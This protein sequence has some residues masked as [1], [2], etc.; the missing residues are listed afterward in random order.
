MP[1]D[2]RREKVGGVREEGKKHRHG[3]KKGETENDSG[4]KKKNKRD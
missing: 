2:W 3:L 1:S 4:K